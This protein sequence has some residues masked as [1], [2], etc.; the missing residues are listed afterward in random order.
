MTNLEKNIKL[1]KNIKRFAVEE[2]GITPN[3]SFEKVI[4]SEE[5]YCLYV[6]QQDKIESIFDIPEDGEFLG[7]NKDAAEMRRRIFSKEGYHTLLF[8]F[9]GY[10]GEE[11]QISQSL[12]KDSTCRL[13][14]VVLHEN[15]HTHREKK[16]L[17]L[18]L[19]IEEAVGN[20]FAYQASLIYFK[21][22]DKKVIPYV[23]SDFKWMLK[24]GDFVNKYLELLNKAYSENKLEKAKELL[25][26]A[27]IEARELG[28]NEEINN[29]F[30]LREKNYYAKQI[31]VFKA[32][33]NTQPQDY[34][35]D[36]TLLLK[37]LEGI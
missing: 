9:E 4:S 20:Y 12:L 33:K 23:E 34:V 17:N 27:E 19:C 31:E 8:S 3:K 14:Y 26:D 22:H 29:A 10:G 5:F 28:S 18:E 24:Y 21:K 25:F 2:M 16:E 1:V 36:T 6:S 13:A 32:L 35:R 30:F 15:F 7:D 37:L 11:C